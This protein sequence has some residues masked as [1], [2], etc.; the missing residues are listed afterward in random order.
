MFVSA[1]RLLTFQDFTDFLPLLPFIRNSRVYIRIYGFVKFYLGVL[2]PVSSQ[3]ILL[4]SKPAIK[5]LELRTSENRLFEVFRINDLKLHFLFS[6]MLHW[7]L[8]CS[9]FSTEMF[10]HLLHVQ[11]SIV[12]M[13][14][15][16][17]IEY[18][19]F[20]VI[21]RIFLVIASTCKRIW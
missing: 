6:F 21:L 10:W 17:Y 7:L 19:H 14:Y 8:L 11:K 18:S 4:H 13:S 3:Q 16:H 12:R 1:T 5:T 2:S 20:P 9:L 15:K